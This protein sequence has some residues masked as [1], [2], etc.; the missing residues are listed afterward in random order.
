VFDF[1]PREGKGGGRRAYLSG[2]WRRRSARRRRP[3]PRVAARPPLSSPTR[4]EGRG[5]RDREWCVERTEKGIGKR[6][7]DPNQTR[8]LGAGRPAPRRGSVLT[9]GWAGARKAAEHSFFFSNYHSFLFEFD[10][11]TPPIFFI[12]FITVF[13]T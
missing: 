5:P 13:S 9:S 2:A 4:R 3:G 7:R 6:R 8:T 12:Q 1:A 10:Q 11:N